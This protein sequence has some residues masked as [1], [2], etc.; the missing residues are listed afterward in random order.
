MEIAWQNVALAIA[1]EDYNYS[2]ENDE[3]AA[4]FDGQKGRAFTI[5]AE[6][7]REQ[8]IITYVGEAAPDP[9]PA[10]PAKAKSNRPPAKP[11]TSGRKPAE[12]PPAAQAEPAAAAPARQTAPTTQA[13]RPAAETP[14]ARLHRVKQQAN[15]IANCWVVSYA[16]ALYAKRQVKDQLGIE[17]TQDQ[18]QACVAT[19]CVQMERDGMHHAMPTGG[20]DAEGFYAAPVEIAHR[21]SNDQPD[22]RQ[23][24]AAGEPSDNDGVA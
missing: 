21:A 18:F 6:G 1:G 3:C 22:S 9:E 19:I 7:S 24:A 8:A 12:R 17:V 10:Q 13:T 15:R 20:V 16:A 23:P 2:T 11:P 5:V 4:F 14:E